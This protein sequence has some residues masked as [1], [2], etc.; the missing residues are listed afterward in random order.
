MTV[1]CGVA[2]S[3]PRRVGVGEQIEV[4]LKHWSGLAESLRPHSSVNRSGLLLLLLAS[5]FLVACVVNTEYLWVFQR[6]ELLGL[7]ISGFLLLYCLVAGFANRQENRWQCDLALS[8]LCFLLYLTQAVYPLGDEWF[9]HVSSRST[10]YSEILGLATYSLFFSYGWSLEII[11]PLFGLATALAYFWT[12]NQLLNRESQHWYFVSRIFFLASGVHLIFFYGYLENTCTSVPFVLLYLGWIVRYM[13]TEG[14]GLIALAF[15]TLFLGLAC[16]FHGQAV[17][18]LPSL[19]MLILYRCGFRQWYLS[20]IKIPA[21]LSLLILMFL[22]VTHALQ[23]ELGFS[24]SPGNINGGGDEMHFVPLTQTG[25]FARHTFFSWGHFR[26]VLNILL[27]GVPFLLFAAP[28]LLLAPL[29]EDGDVPGASSGVLVLLSLAYLGFITLWNF[30]LGYPTDYDL[31]FSLSLLPALLVL[32]LVVRRCST[33][34]NLVKFFILV[35]IALAWTHQSSFIKSMPG[36]VIM[37]EDLNVLKKDGSTWDSVGNLILHPYR[38]TTIVSSVP[39][40]ARQIEISADC[41]DHYL[42]SFFRRGDFRG[43]LLVAP[44]MC[45]GLQTRR[46]AA[47]L[48]LN[49]FD[50][51]V[52][53]GLS[54][55]R[56]YAIGHLRF[57]R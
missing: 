12:C 48:E 35:A 32:L 3:G 42:L 55:D 49:S 10:I 38:S 54:G 11:P 31:M 22:V 20:A 6:G 23:A 53:R 43:E 25:I 50:R 1:Q 37:A 47:P 8:L 45:P 17:F 26:E 15:S 14:P 30:D 56:K 5:L 27:S 18:L 51:V 21:I 16:L 46:L 39:L 4:R 52:V 19:P 36:S 28:L 41:N 34:S 9:H 2:V 7:E 40:H 57:I 29:K 24:I 13:R 44:A 33:N